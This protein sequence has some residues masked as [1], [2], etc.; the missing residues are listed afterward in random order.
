MMELTTGLGTRD[1]VPVQLLLLTRRPGVGL[2]NSPHTATSWSVRWVTVP[3]S[4]WGPGLAMKESLEVSALV[5]LQAPSTHQPKLVPWD[6][7]SNLP[8]YV[9]MKGSDNILR[10][11]C[12]TD[13][14]PLYRPAWL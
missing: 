3:A 6:S 4:P 10:K 8:S 14:G 5:V 13:T 1:Q 12:V 2:F 9:E 7:L 11:P